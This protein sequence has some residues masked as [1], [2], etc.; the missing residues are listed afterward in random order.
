MVSYLQRRELARSVAQSEPTTRG[1]IVQV[2]PLCASKPLA[3]DPSNSSFFTLRRRSQFLLLGP[4]STGP[5]N[6]LSVV[7]PHHQGAASAETP[8]RHWKGLA[9]V[10][11]PAWLNAGA[12]PLALTSEFFLTL[13]F[14][15]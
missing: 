10:T 3:K 15:F 14:A 9:A 12:A 13:R 1:Y 7:R 11:S 5:I 8:S 6:C 4:C 2:Q